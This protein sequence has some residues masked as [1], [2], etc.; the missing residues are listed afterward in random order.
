MYVCMYVCMYIRHAIGLRVVK[1]K[2]KIAG[3]GC[4]GTSSSMV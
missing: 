4:R 2:K 3:F 1:K